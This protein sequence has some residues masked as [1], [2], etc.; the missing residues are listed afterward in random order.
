MNDY[1]LYHYGVKGMKWGVRRAQKYEKKARIARES[2]KE[3]DEIGKAKA[4]KL[5]SKGKN[6]KADRV[7]AK[8][9]DNAKT[10]RS[11][12]KKYEAKAKQENTK[13]NFRDARRDVSKSRSTGAKIATN[14]LAGPFANRTYNSLKAAGAS[15]ASAAVVTGVT[16][17][18]GGPVGHIAVS[19]LYTHAAGKNQLR[20]R[21]DR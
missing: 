5:R 10:D 6:D 11:D 18:L 19:A 4:D 3:W 16:T 17:M 8:Y 21:F 12:A 20:K 13:N 2:A 7:L 9:R 15:D 1:E 14:I